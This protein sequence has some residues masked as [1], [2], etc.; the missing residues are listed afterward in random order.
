MGFM[1]I[2]FYFRKI[3][4]LFQ[5]VLIVIEVCKSILKNVIPDL[6]WCISTYGNVSL[7]IRISKL[8]C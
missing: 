8:T 5:K 2:R 1:G 3:E 6:Q 7:T 4:S